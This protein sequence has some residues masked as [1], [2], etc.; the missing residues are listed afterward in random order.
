MYLA[1][2][3]FCLIS[4]LFLSN[5]NYLFAAEVSVT[6][7]HDQVYLKN[8]ANTYLSS[9]EYL[10]T[11]KTAN[12]ADKW[13]FQILYFPNTL[14]IKANPVINSVAVRGAERFLI[15][16]QENNVFQTRN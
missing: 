3:V 9:T 1:L 15:F 13:D 5:L 8:W 16:K 12:R 14:I 2:K 6:E 4:F 11:D 7:A 10:K